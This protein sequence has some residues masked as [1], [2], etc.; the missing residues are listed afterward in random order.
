MSHTETGQAASAAPLDSPVAS[1][2]APLPEG[3]RQHA[4][5]PENIEI[6]PVAATVPEL[7]Q[8][9]VRAR[10]H[11]PALYFKSGER[12]NGISWDHYARAVQRITGFL[13]AE[14]VAPGDRVAI[15]SYNRPEWHI[16]DLAIL[17]AGAVCVGI[18]LTNSASQC[19]YILDHA[20]VRVALVENREQLAKLLA[21]RASLP[22][23]KRVVLF[24]GEVGAAEKG[25][26]VTW[27]Q[28]LA[29]GDAHD[30]ENPGTYEYRWR[31]VNGADHATY[32]YTSGTTGPPKAAILDHDNLT[33]T[34][35]ALTHSTTLVNPDEDVTLSYLPL[36]HIAERMAGHLLHLRIGHRLYFAEDLG[37]FAANTREAR[38]TFMFGVPRVWEKIE[39]G[40]E[41]QLARARGPKGLIT[42]WAI[43]RGRATIDARVAGRD[44][45]RS[46]RLADRL[47]LARLRQAIGFGR[48]QGISTGAAPISP[49]TLE[50]FW[51]LGLPLYEV[52]GQS[53]GSGP[54][55]TNRP[56]HVK[57]GTVGPPLPGSEIRVAADGEVLLRG[58]NVF[59]GYFKDPVATAEAL[60]A[61]GWLHSGDVGE[62]D[63]EG[64]L[65]ITD[66]KKDLVITAGG[67]N[68]SP[69]NI[70][71]SLR[72][73]PYV[74]HAVAIGDRRPF[75]AALMTIDP[76]RITALAVAVGEAPDVAVL[77]A[78]KRVRAIFQAGVDAVNANLS[79]AEQVKR[80]EILPADLSLEAG[81]LTPTMKV[82]RRVINDRYAGVIEGIY[83]AGGRAG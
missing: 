54:S 31:A 55:S 53:E 41:G 4:A 25:L 66:R 49:S 40:V 35:E 12:W 36:A 46:Y 3:R 9:Q 38:P 11:E 63:A 56:G 82:K 45:G 72:R 76:E 21:V 20:E 83:A 34:V 18:Y 47:V 1:R 65:R 23:L 50:F 29:A 75:M 57:L 42:R 19:Q 24:S 33:A 77:A 80:F 14:G 22:S 27:A 5:A 58:P 16:G 79:S 74:G 73:Q 7:F 71:L 13:L 70:E 64:F 60:D 52:Y 32:I 44:P 59:K 39:Q 43:N 67:K 81:E 2:D 78:S 69:S 10:R 51:A 37:H 26:V 17:H 30:V 48:V 62:I 8:R 68:V 28:A 15:L 61:D 6:V